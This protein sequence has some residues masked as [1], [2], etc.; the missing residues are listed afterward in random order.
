MEFAGCDYGALSRI[1]TI[2]V[3]T[4]YLFVALLFK[5]D[6]LFAPTLV[7]SRS[8]LD[9]ISTEGAA[10]QEDSVGY[11]SQGGMTLTFT[12]S[13]Y[14]TEV[15][16]FIWKLGVMRAT[17]ICTNSKLDAW[18]DRQRYASWVLL[19]KID[20]VWRGRRYTLGLKALHCCKHASA[21]GIEYKYSF[22]WYFEVLKKLSLW[23]WPLY[24]SRTS[25]IKTPDFTLCRKRGKLK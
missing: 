2:L 4:P 20:M 5:S 13:S 9:H 22:R 15:L 16:D 11:T 3:N 8:L 12:V 21:I 23:R 25:G 6:K 19:K 10:P 7:L 14:W 1:E 18:K 24:D 17:N